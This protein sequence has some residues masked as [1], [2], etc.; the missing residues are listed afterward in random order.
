MSRYGFERL[1][2]SL[3]QRVYGFDR[4][5]VGH[6]DEAYVGD[7]VRYL[8]AWPESRRGDV[9]EIG[10]GLGDI[11]KRLRFTNRVGL[12]HDAQVVA[13]AAL[14]AR[15]RRGRAPR[16]AASEFPGDPINGRY[17]AIVMVNWIHQI[18]TERL[19]EAIHACMSRNL[20]SGGAVVLDTVQDPAY[21]YNHDVRV[22][23]PPG[24]TIDHLGGYARGRHV[25]VVR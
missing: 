13:A 14:L 19:R 4:W 24:S 20:R 12:D 25:W 16:F 1:K 17:D 2:R 9:L 15:F 5:H 3:L 23:A 11:L 22:L 7:I 8:N 6:A 21:M 10:C 18:D